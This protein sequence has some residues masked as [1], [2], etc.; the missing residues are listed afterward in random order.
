MLRLEKLGTHQHG[1]A[2]DIPINERFYALRF[3][4]FHQGS[5]KRYVVYKVITATHPYLLPGEG[6]FAF[7]WASRDSS[8]SEADVRNWQEQPKLVILDHQR[9]LYAAHQDDEYTPAPS[10]KR[11]NAN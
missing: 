6:N 2:R 7:T 9:Q 5:R 11:R 4:F 10:L 3:T 1:V 8:I